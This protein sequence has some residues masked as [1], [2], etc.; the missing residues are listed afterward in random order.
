MDPI[1]I[2]PIGVVRTPYVEK[3]DAPRQPEV[4]DRVD[5][6]TIELFPHQNFEQALEDLAGFDRIWL[7]TWFDRAGSWK[8]KILTPR[9]RTKR[10]VFATR[11]PHRPNPIGLTCVR[12][13]DVKGL[14]I[15]VEGTDLL[16]GTPVLDIKPYLPY[17]DAFTDVRAGWTDDLAA[18]PYTVVIEPDIE[19]A[20]SELASHARRVLAHDPFP[21]PYRRIKMLDDG[22]YELA[23]K[24]WRCFY[25]INGQVVTVTAI[26]LL[27]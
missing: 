23:M 3:Y 12:L 5:Q 13:I 4:D 2:Q 24:E 9:D 1:T 11:S 10:G 15:R 22:S 25:H 6:A 8:P 27:P 14:V 26:V 20:A 18:T 17:A 19:A 16:D 21:H 7:I